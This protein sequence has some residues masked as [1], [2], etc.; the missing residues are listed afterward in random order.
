MTVQPR[1]YISGSEVTARGNGEGI[2]VL[3]WDDNGKPVKDQDK[4]PK[5]KGLIIIAYS[6]DSLTVYTGS[7]G[8]GALVL[9]GELS[10][11]SLKNV[12]KAYISSSTINNEYDWGRKVI[13]R[14]H[15]DTG[16]VIYTGAAAVSV[17]AAV[18][19]ALNTIHVQ[20]ETK[21]YIDKSIV[22]ALEGIEVWALTGYHPLEEG[23]KGII[24][25]GAATGTTGAIAGVVSV[26]M[27]ENINE[28]FVKEADLFSRGTITIKSVHNVKLNNVI[29]T[30]AGDV[31]SGNGGSIFFTSLDNIARAYVEAARLNA[32]KAIQI[33][34]RS[35]G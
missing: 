19:T 15:Q 4:N 31:F 27:M 18:G 33:I 24:I 21:A 17:G 5:E 32:S 35:P 14:A 20:H 6:Q 34:A 2:E 23:K 22:Y 26:L 9:S 1:A 11:N 13:I 10:A 28:A 25:A 7:L 16:V 12:T 30:G 3:A 29:A 8:I